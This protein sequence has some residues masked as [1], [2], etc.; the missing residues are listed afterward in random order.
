M[1]ILAIGA[2]PDDIELGCGGLIYK[3]A[4][5]GHNVFMYMLTRG[6]A[7]GNPEERTRELILT[8]KFIGANTLWIDDFE[9]TRLS[10]NS[11]LIE[12]IEFF[13]NKSQADIVLTHAPTDVHH[14]HKA[15]AASTI[16]AGR[17]ARNIL[18]YE[19]PL[20]KN[21]N[22]Q[23]FYDISDVVNEKVELIKLFRSQRDK[24]YLK[25]NAI[26]GLAEYRALQSRL[27]AKN[28]YT[29][30]SFSHE[31]VEAFEVL[32]ACMDNGFKLWGESMATLTRNYQSAMPHR[33]DQI[34]EVVGQ[35]INQTSNI[36]Q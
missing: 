23:I 12:H 1:N 29:E 2:H 11:D 33:Y 9:D 18:S 35:A 3:A 19:N 32:K 7:S 17:N 25:A 36:K 14:D 24:I 31:Y 5:N 28:S 30:G 21:F 10:I 13:I 8:S 34:I 22:P 20:T 6:G 4:R 15:V 27:N 16:E 26:K